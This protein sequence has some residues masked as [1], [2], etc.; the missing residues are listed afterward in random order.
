MLFIT[1]A[2]ALH[3]ILA[4]KDRL[5]T[6]VLGEVFHEPSTAP[7]RHERERVQKAKIKSRLYS[8]IHIY[9]ADIRNPLHS[10][11]NSYSVKL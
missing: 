4:F 6:A 3:F 9:Q 1:L 11:N 5:E 8:Y 10:Y 2:K 7:F